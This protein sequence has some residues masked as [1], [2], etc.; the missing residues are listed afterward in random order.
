MTK[1][2]ALRSIPKLE[3]LYVIF[4]RLTHLPY[5][6]CNSETFDDEV[7]VYTDETAAIAKAKAL[8]EDKRA[9]IA[10]KVEKHSLLK[11]FSE[12]YAYGVNALVYQTGE[13]IYHMQLDEI[14]RRPDFTNVPEERRPLENPQLQMSMIY[15]MQ[16][17]RRGQK[18]ADRNQFREMEEEMVVNMMRARYL[19][20][21]KELE[22]EDGKKG[23]QLIFLKGADGAPM[24]PVFSDGAEYNRFRGKQD[25]KVAV[26]DFEK[27]AKMNLPKEVTGFII[28]P[29]GVGVPLPKDYMQ[30]L[31]QN[32]SWR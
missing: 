13:D 15:Y 21:F 9:A 7:F 3:Q 1:E 10:I 8:T 29:S 30:R 4:S 25:F 18:D 17:L 23:L 31:L 14:V 24:V 19:I 28:N 5:I 11:I 27:M 12:F 6:E 22:S 32:Y 2:E 16:E 26:T 20:P